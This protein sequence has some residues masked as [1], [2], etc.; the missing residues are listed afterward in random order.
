MRRFGIVV[1]LLTFSFINPAS[2]QDGWKSI[3]DGTSLD[4]WKQAGPGGFT[5]QEDGS[6]V[7]HGGMGLFY[8]EEEAFQDFELELD[9]KVNKHNANAGV[10]VR[11]PASD[12]PWVAVREGYEIQI[13]NSRDPDHVTGS[14]Y[15]VSAPFRVP[16][17]EDDSWNTFLIR[18]TGQRYQIWL[19]GE[20]INDFVGNRSREGHIGLQNH[21]DSSRVAFRNV[22]VRTL[23][24]SS[25][26]NLAELAPPPPNEEEEIRVLMVTATH[27]F[28][29]G[30]AIQA[31]N[32]V[33]MAL[34]ETTELRVDTTEN[35]ELLNR[36]NLAQY[37][38]LFLANST[39]RAVR[40]EGQPE[41][42]E[43][44]LEGTYANYDILLQIPD[45]ETPGSLALSGTPDSLTGAISFRLFPEVSPL[46]S[47]AISGDS[48]L[49]RW[50]V[51][52]A[53]LL[54][55]AVKLVGDS[56]EGAISVMNTSMPLT[57]TLAAPPPEEWLLTI[58]SPQGDMDA[59]LSLS[60]TSGTMAFF[61]SDYPL[62]DLQ[63]DTD[64][65]SFSFDSGDFGIIEGKGAMTDGAIEGVFSAGEMTLSFTGSLLETDSL[66]DEETP[67]ITADQQASILEF[68]RDGK[69]IAVA[70]AGL[71]ALYNWNEYRDMVGGGLFDSHPWTQSVHINIE[72]ADNPAVAH[73]GDGFWIRDEIYVLDENPR[74]NSRVLMSLDMNSVVQ[75]GNVAGNA[76]NDYPIA[77]V[78]QHLGGRVFVTALGHFADVWKTPS[79]QEHVVQG[80]RIAA[81]RSNANLGGRRVK[82]VIAKDVWPDDIAV[83]ERGNV[84]IAE[85]RGKMFRYDAA[86]G[87][88][89]YIGHVI[90]PDPTNIEHGLYGI[91]VDPA[92]YDGSPYI[93]L[94]YAEPHT[95]INKLVRVRFDGNTIV[96]GSQ[97][98]LLRVPT[99]PTCC[100]QAGDLEWGPD[101]TLYLSTGD[102]GM[103][104]VRPSWEVSEER[105]EAFKER[106]ALNDYHWARQADSERSAQNLQD[107]RGKILRIHRDGT[108]PHDNPFF[109]EPGVRWE[110]YAYGLRNP[111]RFKVD[112]QTGALYIGVVGP[113]A[114]YDYDEYNIS[115][116]GGENFGWPRTLGSL[117]YNEWT[118]E[119]IPNYVPP[120]WEYDYEGGG[121]SATVGPIYRHQGDGAF[122]ELMQNKLFVFD[123]ARRW[124][125]YGTLVEGTFESDQE[126]D[127]RVDVPNISMPATRLVNIKTFD[128]LRETAPISIEQGSD[129]SIYVAEF[130]GFWD[131]GPAAQVTRYRWV[132]DNRPPIGDADVTPKGNYEYH[133]DGSD[134]Y[135]PDLDLLTFEWDF[136]DGKAS[137]ERVSQHS[138]QSPGTYTAS[139]TVIDERGQQIVIHKT[140]QVPEPDI[141]NE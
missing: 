17:M 43:V 65:I 45:N 68:L 13:D 123:W 124:I 62:M 26:M 64:S 50:S 31:Q 40:P 57:G 3:F 83:D 85:L 115:K 89:A 77:W 95:F 44:T 141:L 84:W 18:V 97:E 14:V 30:A 52:G 119:M 79:F 134:I 25:P 67:T 49:F 109:G 58:D 74:W 11:F 82:E 34:S 108:I 73:F 91:E 33:M 4:G 93:Y 103:S 88:V 106:N 35:L 121:R 20:Q 72:D 137:K 96:Q 107:L 5:L 22:R 98:V 122:P 139:L 133:F 80:I 27:G 86:T 102:T 128:Q 110:I 104:E 101:S 112:H 60:D 105:L 24:E 113:D 136:G 12:D 140:V 42:D 125:K 47:V 6:M 59:T 56:L 53:G 132:E 99:E 131:P 71:D 7:S 63:S 116:E 129:G 127:V 114:S 111:Y 61:G 76:R 41:P 94:Y 32:E 36:D 46:D 29:H 92:F 69:G 39:L 2:G 118:P 117:F 8:Y 37:D 51:S 78:R 23:D 66:E 10:F 28:R 87:D 48:L 38:V 55:G 100:H 19:N 75:E 9:W 135:D 90:T 120:I 1:T 21:D 130:D 81:G 126:N 54:E 70:H 15:A 16:P 138:Y